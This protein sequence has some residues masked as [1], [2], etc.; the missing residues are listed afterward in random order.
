MKSIIV[1]GFLVLWVFSPTISERAS[2][3]MVLVILS[4]RVISGVAAWGRRVHDRYVELERQTQIE[5]EAKRRALPPV[6]NCGCDVWEMEKAIGQCPV[7]R[8]KVLAA[9]VCSTCATPHHVDCWG[10]NGGC[11]TYA[12]GGKKFVN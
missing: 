2:I 12:C 5:Y 3:A 11:G 4:P 7:C 9:R 10:Y 8:M 1:F 6:D